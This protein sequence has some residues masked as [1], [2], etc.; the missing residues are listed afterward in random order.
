MRWLRGLA[1]RI[2]ALLATRRIEDEL[3]EEIRFHLERDIERNVRLG[4]NAREAR[5][6]AYLR[7]GGVEVIK[8]Q[9]RDESGVRW[10][11]DL[12][13]DAR[14]ALRGLR[15]APVFTIAALLSLGVGIGVNTAIFSVV[16]GVL[17]RPLSYPEAD[18]LYLVRIRWHDYSSPLSDADLLGFMEGRQHLASVAGIWFRSGGFTVATPDGPEVVR[19]AWVTDAITGVFGVSPIVGRSFA[20]DDELAVLVSHRYWRTRL[21]GSRAAIGSTIE[22]DGQAF[23]IVGVMPPGFSLPGH[24]E[25][26]IWALGRVREPTRRGPFYL[27]VIARLR[28]G[29]TPD[30]AEAELRSVELRVR[31]GYP[32]SASNWRYY[33][34][35]LKQVV[36]GGARS[37]LILFFGAVACVLLIAVANVVN[38]LLARGT[39]RQREIAMRSALGAGRGRLVRQLITES[40]ILGT[41]GAL[42]G[43]ALAAVMMDVFS[44][45][46]SAIV[47]RMN[48]VDIDAS[49]LGFALL[50]GLACGTI[51]GT[52]PALTLPWSRL[53]ELLKEGG[54]GGT[55]GG[56]RGK[57]RK[58]LVV[59]EFAL[60]LSVLICAGL[61][62]KSL[63]RLQTADLGIDEA[64]VVTFR[65]AL[66]D[67]PYS[68]HSAFD[69][70]LTVL[71]QRL[72]AL[73]GVN[74]VG[75]STA[76]PPDGLGLTNNYTVEGEEPG[77]GEP[78]LTA[79]WLLVTGS[80]FD[81]LRIPLRRGRSFTPSDREGQPG[82]VVVNEAFV[83]KHFPG[84][85][86]LS[87]RLK[88]GSWSP[89]APW[90][91]VV[92]VVGDV[93][94][95]SGAAGGVHPT[96]YTA[97]RQ[98]L[99]WH[100]P[101]VVMRAR[102]DPESLVSQV[103]REVRALEPR[104][105]LRDVATMEQLVRGSTAVE[106][107]RGLLLSLLAAVALVM[108]ATGIY[109]VMSYHVASLRRETAIRRAL[110][111]R[112]V[113]VVGAV[114][115]QA[116]LLAALGVV[117][118]SA[119]ALL[120]T[121][122]LTAFLFEVTPTDA[123]AFAGAA[124]VLIAVAMV[125][126]L[127]PSVRAARVDPVNVLREE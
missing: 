47:P 65:L 21:Q 85:D 114:L 2:R 55:A 4:M 105:P 26:D 122:A 107:F 121:R 70:F 94:Y 92:G 31:E 97:Y 33:M 104:T 95:R 123:T 88:S 16:N 15:K 54:R 103:R 8:E 29:T 11:K 32:E 34:L 25:G 53:G 22:L 126:C 13:Q 99:A 37:T 116:L 62:I 98:N 96:V 67:D 120:L 41:L 57:T 112:N 127:V 49:V 56:R 115:R 71:E 93:T 39:F 9:V 30:L 24:E 3:D 73:P 27:R 102:G 51:A 100:A 12:I 35:P 42:I 111:A 110:G 90:L 69:N 36:V 80:Y 76:L 101:Y 64:G 48:E 10:I 61:L 79:E 91:T 87:K 18:H 78:R 118:G 43:L 68:E 125:A 5:R 58:L 23:S 109:G 83:R 113:Q 106:R 7:F 28:E 72:G 46:A 45:G 89:E 14:Y 52:L 77:P 84:E 75:F 17:L 74:T 19:G 50:L 1:H 66:P 63:V 117:V 20:P 86:P 108:A 82:V 40:T 81:A 60:A 124:L 44:T 59:A 38:L 6:Q 119:G